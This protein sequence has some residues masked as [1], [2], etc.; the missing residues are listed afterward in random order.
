MPAPAAVIIHGTFD[1]NNDLQD[2]ANLDVQEF[3]SKY[4]REMRDRKDRH[5]NLR[6]REYFN[7][8]VALSLTA[9]VITNAGL[10]AQHPGTRVTSLV[11]YAV[12][13]RGFDPAIGTMMLDDA[14]DTLSLEEDLKT[15]LNITH[16]PFVVSAA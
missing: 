7:P 15:A 2:D 12:E 16:A 3:K 10:A 14:E 4:G 6:R 5:G 1:A 8:I 9:F 11:N 13:K